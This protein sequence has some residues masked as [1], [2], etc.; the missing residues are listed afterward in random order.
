VNKAAVKVMK[1]DS[2]HVVS[3]LAHPW[4]FKEDCKN[5]R[6]EDEWWRPGFDHCT[7]QA[8]AQV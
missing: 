2:L 4:R 3:D 7:R 8:G 1:R 5:K 6:L